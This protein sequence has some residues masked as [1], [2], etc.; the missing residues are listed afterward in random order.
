MSEFGR[1]ARQNGNRGT[2]HGHGTAFFALGGGVKGGRV[3]GQWPGLSPDKLFEGRDLAITTDYRDFFA[4]ACVR[5]MGIP[6]T[7]LTKIF[8]AHATGPEK[9]RGFLG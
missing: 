8:P 7:E 9:F 2:D 3:L 5:H 6:A 4:E 1:T